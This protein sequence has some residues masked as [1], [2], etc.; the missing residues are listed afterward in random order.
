MRAI[1]TI[2][3]ILIFHSVAAQVV[4]EWR[5]PG[6]TGKYPDTGLLKEWPEDGPEKLWSSGEVLKGYSSP[7][8]GESYIYVTGR[9]DDREYITA[10]DFEGKKVWQVPFGRAWDESYPDTRTTP[11]IYNGKLYMVSGQGEVVCHDALT[12]KQLW[13]VNAN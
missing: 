9:K 4:S 2:F 10:L 3:F 11:T 12:G 1:L 13:Y 7:A 8:I 6:R 5:G